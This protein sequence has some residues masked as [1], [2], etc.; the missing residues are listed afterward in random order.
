M[1]RQAD[2]LRSESLHVAWA[3]RQ[4]LATARHLGER[5]TAGVS[6]MA[7][8][9]DAAALE[10]FAVNARALAHFLWRQRGDRGVRKDDAV[11][12]DWF[13]EGTWEPEPLP[14]ELAEVAERTGWGVAHI[15]YTRLREHPEW[16]YEGIAHRIAY[17]FAWFL[18]DAEP[19]RVAP[20]LREWVE[21]RIVE[22]RGT[23]PFELIPR[24]PRVV[25]TP[26]HPSLWM[27]SF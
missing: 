9:L 27:Q 22:W 15:S 8:P 19:G 26:A 21:A 16:D 17:R 24:T 20:G 12:G 6:V 2:A 13:D 4:L 7:D 18:V 23:L 25:A 11:A 10:C 3:L 5:H 14:E 1:T